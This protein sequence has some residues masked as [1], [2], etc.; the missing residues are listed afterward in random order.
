MCC[1]LL[2]CQVPEAGGRP[3]GL[4]VGPVP[5]IREAVST[6]EELGKLSYVQ[7]AMAAPV[8]IAQ[9]LSAPPHLA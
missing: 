7:K 3:C 2:S 6:A 5:G 8:G 1:L 9:Q 4:Y